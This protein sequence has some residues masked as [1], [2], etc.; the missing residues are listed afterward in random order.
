MSPLHT[1]ISNRIQTR[2]AEPADAPTVRHLLNY[3]GRQPLNTWWWEEHLGQDVFTLSFSGRR[4][5]GALFMWPDEGPVGWVR[6]A[7]L[8]DRCSVSRWLDSS[9]SEF[10]APLRCRGARRLA[11]IDNGHWAGPALRARGFYVQTRLVT[12]IKMDRAL[13]SVPARPVTV[14]TARRE[15]IPHIRRV[16]HAAFN[17][18]WWL[19]EATLER[20]RHEADCFLVAEQDGCYMGYAEARIVRGGAHIGRLAVAPRYQGQGIGSLLLN[21]TLRCL[22][23]A[24]AMRVFLNTQEKNH[25]SRRLYRR[26]GFQELAERT[27]VW[28]R[29]L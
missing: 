24:G 8:A 23:E 22:W 13:R 6:L 20:M 21:E 15:E 4:P 10:Y 5:V 3:A 1:R 16:D 11:W 19:G 18:P 25:A 12:L 9:L 29:A 28:E 26:A 14:R 17:P 7:V 2:I 27:T